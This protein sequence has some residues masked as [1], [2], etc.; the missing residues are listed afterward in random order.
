MIMFK[1]ILRSALSCSWL[2]LLALPAAAQFAPNRYALFL[3]DAPA[4]TRF[5]GRDTLA[6]AAARGYRAQ[7]ERTQS[8]VLSALQARKIP[9][10]GAVSTLLNAVFVVATPDR[11]AEMAA[12]PGVVAVRPMRQGELYLNKATQLVNAPAAWTAPGIGGQGNAGM[13]IK[14]GILDTGIDQTHPTFQDSSLPSA[15]PGFPSV[16]RA[17]RRTA[18]L[19]TTR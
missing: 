8:A 2:V 12:I 6:G 3:Q 10:T 11:V 19:R 4:A 18:S 1:G 16:R 15:G 13:G 9:V 14:I 5:T 17:T 7:L